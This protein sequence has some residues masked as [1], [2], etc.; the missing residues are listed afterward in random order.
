LEDALEV[1]VKRVLEDS[2]LQ[3]TILQQILASARSYP[4]SLGEGVALLHCHCDGISNPM[5][6]VGT[7]GKGDKWQ[8]NNLKGRYHTIMMLLSPK[9]D[10]QEI[11]LNTLADL[12]RRFLD[13]D[14]ITQL[15]TANSS[16]AICELMK[17]K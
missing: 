5:L 9:G 10:P 15:E 4:L 13:K 16:E 8:F 1:M 14:F 6:L 17:R 11:H 12:A 7:G 3:K 2:W